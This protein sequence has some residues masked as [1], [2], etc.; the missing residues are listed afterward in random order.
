MHGEVNL[1]I[2]QM[3]PSHYE[4]NSGHATRCWKPLTTNWGNKM[5]NPLD[6]IKESGQWT[7]WWKHREISE[8]A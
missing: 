8:Y 6:G 3:I 4:V 2:C 7:L 5:Q 1:L